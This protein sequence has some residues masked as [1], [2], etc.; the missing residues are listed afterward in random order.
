MYCNTCHCEFGGWKTR[1]PVC[2]QILSLKVIAPGQFSGKSISQAELID[3]IQAAG[4]ELTIDLIS[5]SVDKFRKSYIIGFGFGY[6][7]S[8]SMQGILNNEIAVDLKTTSVGQ[9][10][11][12]NIFCFGFGYA[13]IQKMSGTI[14]GLSLNLETVKIGKDRQ[15]NILGFGYGFAWAAEMT[16]TIGNEISACLKVTDVSRCKEFIILKLGYG[17]AW[18]HKAQLTLSLK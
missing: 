3:L 7:W 13:W 6:A 12:W 11:T 4:G 14:G 9:D 17:Y 5:T 8:R 18:E 1:C 10:K 16:G 2:Q 15:F